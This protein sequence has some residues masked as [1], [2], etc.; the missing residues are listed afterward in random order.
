MLEFMG[1]PNT[2]IPFVWLDAVCG[3]SLGV[4]RWTLQETAGAQDVESA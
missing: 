2:E 4:V 1:I 3:R